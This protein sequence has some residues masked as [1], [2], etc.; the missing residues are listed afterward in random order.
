MVGEEWSGRGGGGE[1]IS[2]HLCRYLCGDLASGSSGPTPQ[3]TGGLVSPELVSGEASPVRNLFFTIGCPTIERRRR[4]GLL[5][6][7]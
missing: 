2:M 7:C 4:R 5:G 3:I 1:I 6:F